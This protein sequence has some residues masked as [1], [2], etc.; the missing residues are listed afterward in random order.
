V[1]SH[2]SL[3]ILEK[4]CT[5]RAN[6][7]VPVLEKEQRDAVWEALRARKL[8]EKHQLVQVDGRPALAKLDDLGFAIESMGR[9]PK[10]DPAFFL[11][12]GAAGVLAGRMAAESSRYAGPID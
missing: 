5:A 9:T 12:A 10:D 2:H 7:A 6:V 3:T 11:A 1:V 4:V 8:E